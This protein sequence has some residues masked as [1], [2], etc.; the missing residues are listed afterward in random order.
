MISQFTFLGAAVC[1]PEQ[2]ATTVPTMINVAAVVY[3][4]VA[5]NIPN[6]FVSVIAEVQAQIEKQ[7]TMPD[8]APII[9]TARINSRGQQQTI[10]IPQENITVIEKESTYFVKVSDHVTNNLIT[11]TNTYCIITD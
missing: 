8:S 1:P 5:I 7:Q 10:T 6:A 3:D 4:K 2:N 9:F 11:Y